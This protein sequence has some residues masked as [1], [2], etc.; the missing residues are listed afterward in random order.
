LFVSEA[1]AALQAG[2]RAIIMLRPKNK[3]I[4]E[5]YLRNFQYTDSFLN[6]VFDG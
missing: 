6:I 5:T 1:T 3:P 4:P 2:C